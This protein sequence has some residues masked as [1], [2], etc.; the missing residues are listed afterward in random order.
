MPAKLAGCWHWRTLGPAIFYLHCGK[1]IA[2][3]MTRVGRRS[4]EVS[5]P[6]GR[7]DCWGASTSG[8]DLPEVLR[9]YSLEGYKGLSRLLCF[10]SSHWL[11]V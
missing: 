4:L 1:H 10:H 6:C 3:C 11:W 2:S 5:H 9:S 7:G 8:L